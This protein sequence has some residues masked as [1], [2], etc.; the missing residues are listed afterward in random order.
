MKTKLLLLLAMASFLFFASCEDEFGSS[1]K[2]ERDFDL[3]GFDEVDLGDAFKIEIVRGGSFKV[4][5]RGTV[6]DIND[7]QLRV[8]NGRLTGKYEPGRNNRK[9]TEITIEMPELHYLRLSGATKTKFYGFEAAN[10]SLELEVSGASE[11]DGLSSWKYLKL[12][13]SGASEVTLE[14]TTP[15]IDA[16]ISGVS[17]FYGNNLYSAEVHINVSG[18]SKAN[19]RALNK[20]TGS[21]SGN[22]E[23]GYI[24]DPAILDVNLQDNSKL[25]KL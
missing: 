10:D 5:A 4:K 18:V 3:S 15:I 17:K 22:S 14:G 13:I 23:L 21:V 11:L 7:L 20:L 8:S 1:E 25:R 6:R 9:R 16:D 19:V 12:K 24:G 2:I